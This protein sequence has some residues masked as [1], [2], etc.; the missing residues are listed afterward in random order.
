MAGWFWDQIIQK[1]SEEEVKE[2]QD[3]E[4]AQYSSINKLLMHYLMIDEE[5]VFATVRWTALDE[6]STWLRVLDTRDMQGMHY[7]ALFTMEGL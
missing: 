4:G 6:L 1:R 2:Q 3:V 5:T 7:T